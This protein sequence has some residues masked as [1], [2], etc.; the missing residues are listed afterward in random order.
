MKAGGGRAVYFV[1]QQVAKRFTYITALF[2][3]NC[4]W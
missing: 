4:Q 3:E 1:D 2:V